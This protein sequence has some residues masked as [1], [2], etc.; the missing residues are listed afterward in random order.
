VPTLNVGINT[1]QPRRVAPTVWDIIG[2]FNS[3][4]RVNDIPHPQPLS[5]M[6]RGGAGIYHAF[7]PLLMHERGRG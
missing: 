6:R 5:T 1:G 7:S 2:F 3:P 4:F